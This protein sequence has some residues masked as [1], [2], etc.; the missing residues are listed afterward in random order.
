MSWAEEDWTVGLSGR[1]L[2]K[3][4]ELQIQQE[5]LNKERQQKQL[6]LDST[7]TSLNKQTVKYEQVRGELQSV[8]R[9]LQAARKEVQAGVCARDR[10]SQ[11]LQVKQAQVCSLEGQ[12]ASAR[13]LTHTLEKEVKRLEAE[14]EKLQN[15]S[16]SGDSMFSTPCWSGT[17][18]W[19]QNGGRQEDRQGHRGEALQARQQLKFSDPGVSP[20]FPRQQPKGTPH[21]LHQSDSSTPSAV[22]PWERDDPKAS[23]RGR[24]APPPSPPLPSFS[25]VISRGQDARDCGMMAD[26]R[27]RPDMTGP[28]AELQGRV[29]AVEG[30]LKAE[31]ERFRQTQDAL[32]AARKDLTARE[33]SLQRTKDELSLA[34]SR[35]SQ[36]TDRAQSLEQRV[37]QLQEE[38]KCQRQNSESSRLQHQQRSRD[39]EKQHQRDLSE[40]QKEHQSVEKQHQQDMNK[41]NQE[42]Q[43]ARTL[44]N[45]LQAQSEKVAVQKQALQRDVET[46]KEK[47]TWTEGEWKESQKKEAQI[48]TKLTE[49]LRESE[50]QGVALEQSRRRERGLEEEVKRLADE[51]AEAL[52]RV[53]ELEDQKTVQLSATPMTLVQY[54]PAGQSFA[55]VTPSRLDRPTQHTF[56][57]QPR[58]TSRGEQAREGRGTANYPAEREPGEGIDSEHVT[59]FGS[60]DSEKTPG[61]GQEGRGEGGGQH[62]RRDKEESVV[63]G[64]IFGKEASTRGE[65]TLN[66]QRS[67]SP[68]DRS[69]H[70]SS[71]ASS[72]TDYESETLS[73]HSKHSKPR[74][75]VTRDAEDLQAE[76][77]ELRSELQDIKKELQRRLE[78]LETQRTAEAEAR[79]KLKQ[80]SRK[81]ADTS[82]EREKEEKEKRR[83]LE[84]GKAETGRLKE[85]L[86]ALEIKVRRERKER[87]RSVGDAER[88]REREDRESE[89]VLLNLQL[90]KQLAELKTELLIE[91]EEREREKEDERMRNKGIEGKIDL[92]VQLKELQAELEELKKHGRLKGKNAEEKNTPLTYLTL[93]S[94][95]SCVHDNKL[96]PSTDQQRHL[97]VPINLQDTAVSQATGTTAHIIHQ[98]GTL[99]EALAPARPVCEG[100][101]SGQSA[102]DLGETVVDGE[103]Q[104]FPSDLG[105][106]TV[107]AKTEVSGESAVYLQ[108]GGLSASELAQEVERLRVESASEAGRARQ[109]Q[110]K[111]EALQSQVTSQTQQLTLAFDHQSRHIQ[112]LLAEL[113][114]KEGAILRQGQELQ[115]CKDELVAL[116]EERPKQEMGRRESERREENQQQE[117]GIEVDEKESGA[118]AWPQKEDTHIDSRRGCLLTLSTEAASVMEEST[119][120]TMKP[121]N[122]PQASSALNVEGQKNCVTESHYVTESASTLGSHSIK[123]VTVKMEDSAASAQSDVSKEPAEITEAFKVVNLTV[124]HCSE[125]MEQAESRKLQQII[126]G[127][128]H[129]ADS[130]AFRR[131]TEELHQV[132][133]DL[134]LARTETQRLTAEIE[135][136][137][138]PN[139]KPE[140]TSGH[141]RGGE[142]LSQELQAL[143][144]ENQ[145]LLLKLQ[146][147]AA[148]TVSERE[149]SFASNP[150][151]SP[152]CEGQKGRKEPGQ[153][154]DVDAV[155]SEW[156]NALLD[157]GKPKDEGRLQGQLE[158]ERETETPPAPLQITCLQQQLVALQAEL[159]SLS[160]ENQRQAE[161]LAVWRL[162][163]QAPCLDSEEPV[164]GTAPGLNTG[165]Y[166]T[167]TV[168]KEDELLLSCN[169]SRLYGRTLA[170]RIQHCNSPESKRPQNSNRK[171]LE[172]DMEDGLKYPQTKET[173]FH[174]TVKQ[175][176]QMRA[177]QGDVHGQHYSNEHRKDEGDDAEVIKAVSPTSE[178]Q[179]KEPAAQNVPKDGTKLNTLQ[180]TDETKTKEVVSWHNVD[181]IGLETLKDFPSVAGVDDESTETLAC[182]NEQPRTNQG[183]PI[184]TGTKEGIHS[185]AHRQTTTVTTTEWQTERTVVENKVVCAKVTAAGE[186]G[187]ES[188]PSVA[189]RSASTQT[190]EEAAGVRVPPS[191]PSAVPETQ[192]QYTQTEEEDE[193]PTESPP[194]SPVRISQ[195]EGDRMLF[196]GSFP[197]PA[198]PARLAER[199]RRNRSQMSAAYDDT[200]YE[201]YGLPEVV[202]KGFADIPSGPACPYIVRRGLL[203]TAAVPHPQ[204]STDHGDGLD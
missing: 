194:M 45:A 125:Q 39:L 87:E 118:T 14:L 198:D 166:N 93:H 176:K 131:L 140:D 133:R 2:Q 167:V 89:S 179:T 35:I 98:D 63:D 22:F 195:A 94:D 183:G 127:G 58:R 27:G 9:E 144:Q 34:H 72:D 114:E 97:C 161:E 164:D 48:Q 38:L 184:S 174:E 31:C 51:L 155:I 86:A 120:I 57:A 178:L 102:L 30:E 61:V 158:G 173:H 75:Q 69:P 187:E 68:T 17:S 7:Q 24:P 152:S 74:A 136:A 37:K 101:T 163:T 126:P 146:A 44:Y 3:V 32:A 16:S 76:N 71:S 23:G 47:L 13:T 111:L 60:T 54:S 191:T 84:E 108:R 110:A 4:K 43:Q 171:T 109:T 29:R 149:T 145:L 121:L 143:K 197:I 80:L 12:L 6:Q 165:G 142:R 103:K 91:R 139:N 59:V 148:M 79:T 203:G 78:D 81:Q 157:G 170:S 82:R 62:E 123:T 77:R 64:C 21:R 115:R 117:E 138:G 41:L 154:S 182:E 83:E 147:V 134:T 201:P 100:E 106:T 169:S 66:T 107:D 70:T 190:E 53:K 129:I 52:R 49:S 40:L 95:I 132:Q 177:G 141:D 36:E 42:I 85:A 196:S 15:T 122:P 92:V 10:L 128:E 11:D 26:P 19:D 192:H 186:R 105:E 189:L 168:I 112:D 156:E 162:T 99:K 180:A 202:M 188:V 150:T 67:P 153:M 73:S 185:S 160:E 119:N 193:E 130:P 46:L 88:E 18:P 113:Q 104:V 56:L 181:F 135:N 8:Q 137:L 90:K 151:P 33:Q 55:P 96:L 28:V 25:D 175:T 200:E 1:V 20:T 159:Q 116:R 5:R 199:I 65:N 50:G 204:R 172:L 124:T